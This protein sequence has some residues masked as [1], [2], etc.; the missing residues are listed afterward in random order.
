MESFSEILNNDNSMI[1]AIS[2]QALLENNGLDDEKFIVNS[3]KKRPL[4]DKFKTPENTA[5][6]QRRI[7]NTPKS[8][9]KCSSAENYFLEEDDEIPNLTQQLMSILDNHSEGS[10]TQSTDCINELVGSDHFNIIENPI[11][12]S[13][14]VCEKSSN[15]TEISTS[16]IS[17]AKKKK[18][19]SMT[20]KQ[21]NAYGPFFGL[22]HR[23]KDFLLRLKGIPSLY[24]W[25]EECLNLKSI[26]DRRNLIYALPTSG[27]KTLVAEILMLRE[28]IL[29]KMNV[30][31]VLPYVS[32][33]QEKVQDLMPLAVEF[34]FLVEEYCSGKGSIPPAK[35]RNKSSIYICTMEKANIL[36]DSLIE[37]KRIKELSMVVVDELHMVGDPQRGHV[38]E[39]FLAKSNFVDGSQ[40]QVIGMSATIAN[41]H[42]IASFLNADIYTRNFRPVELKEYVKIG[43]DLMYIDPNPSSISETFKVTRSHIGTECPDKLSKRDPDSIGVLVLEVALKS[44]CLIFC[45]TK[46]GCENVAKLLID[47]LPKEM[48]TVKTNEKK[49]LIAAIRNDSN[50]SI[51]PLLLQTIP[52]G[53]A[54]HHSGLTNDERRHIEEAFRLQII[55]VIC[56]TS[57]LA[58]GVNLPASRVIIRSPY[59]GPHFLTLSRYKQM[60][61][62]AGRAGKAETGES[63]LICDQKDY[64]KLVNLLTSKMDSTTSAFIS[65]KFLFRSL[66]LDLIGTGLCKSY[67]DLMEFT[68]YL[69]CHVQQEQFDDKLSDVIAKS[70]EELLVEGAIIHNFK[71]LGYQKPIAKFKLNNED[72]YLF[73]GDE[74]SVSKLGKA[75]VNSGM[76]LEEARKVEMD[77][78]KAHECLV[79]T[80]CLHLLFIVAPNEAVESSFL[81]YKVYNESFMKLSAPL[82]RTANVIGITEK[83][84]MKMVINPN[85]NEK[86]LALLK[87]F[88]IALILNELWNGSDVFTVSRMFKV[89]RGIVHKLMQSAASQAYSIFKFCEVFDEYWVFKEILEKFSK[90]LSH[91]CSSEL[92]PLMEL[93]GIKI[94]RAKLMYKE[95]IRTVCDVAALTPEDLVKSVKTI[96]LRQARQVVR[97]AK[98]VVVEELDNIKGK[99]IEMMELTKTKK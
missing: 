17:S 24:D 51:C 4:D 49:N 42:E 7:R 37:S 57:T 60:I 71:S 98:H 52:F 76:S 54:Y 25:Q 70:V 73:P 91:C 86:D 26:A 85:F 90:R 93:P 94:G 22:S 43:S 19:S 6:R 59:V 32:I 58:A 18:R 61:G 53:I 95:G 48:R 82:M 62:R 44:S 78:K 16:E 38:L 80:E 64:Q 83:T 56:C 96:S 92:L 84:A 79:L 65:N 11:T 27:G 87:R 14:Y 99:M 3:I 97:A 74:L 66:A 12:L 20:I 21:I 40:I 35:R 77:L 81:D 23:Q 72:V 36:L 47:I 46:K 69:L 28:V 2:T 45:S 15:A 5:K 41:L 39:S 75:A 9:K 55:T 34:D 50:G 29:R 1:L 30:I 68:K 88:Y 67:E 13:Q 31:F 89:N 33:V 10:L 63:I 8:I